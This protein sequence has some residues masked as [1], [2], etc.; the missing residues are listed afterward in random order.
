MD[1]A[2]QDRQRRRVV[3][4]KGDQHVVWQRGVAVAGYAQCLPKLHFGFRAVFW[5]VSTDPFFEASNGPA[6][7]TGLVTL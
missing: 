4:A 2:G 5:P 6:S 1:A 3:Q 7:E